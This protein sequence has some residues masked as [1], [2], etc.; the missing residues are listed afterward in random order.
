[1]AEI[2]FAMPILPGKTQA[3]KEMFDT[4][5][6]SRKNEAE[7]A[8][9]RHGITKDAWFIQSSPQGDFILGYLETNN[10]QKSMA[11]YATDQDAFAVWSRNTFKRITGIEMSDPVGSPA[12]TE[13]MW[14]S[15]Y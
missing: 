11:A 9:S 14:R 8:N 6:T 12:P 1:M 15:G 5:N 2:M 13:Q 3:A 4:I 7:A 10:P